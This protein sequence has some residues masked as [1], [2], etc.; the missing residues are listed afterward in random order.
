ML[1]V[2]SNNSSAH[3]LSLPVHCRGNQGQHTEQGRECK[4][5][6][7]ICASLLRA[8]H[9]MVKIA[10]ASN[11]LHTVKNAIEGAVDV[12]EATRIVCVLSDELAFRS[13]SSVPPVLQDG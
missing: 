12:D 6:L 5:T 13:L 7:C 1:S 2:I 4:Q 11:S 9:N 3:R 10:P 8:L